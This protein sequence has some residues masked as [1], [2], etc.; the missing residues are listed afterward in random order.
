MKVSVQT[1]AFVGLLAVTICFGWLYLN[2]HYLRGNNWTCVFYTGVRVPM[3]AELAHENI[4]LF[5]GVVGYDAQFYHLIAHDPLFQKGFGHFIDDPRF[6]YR[7]ILIPGL[8]ALLSFGDDSR[9]DSAYIAVVLALV[10]LGAFWLTSWSMSHG[11]SPAWGLLFLVIPATLVTMLLMVVDGALAALTIGAIWY[12]ERQNQKRLFLV[13]ACAALVREIGIF[14]LAGYCLWLLVQRKPRRA[15][16]FGTAALP[17]FLWLWFVQL[18]TAAGSKQMLSAIPFRG[19]Y[20]AV[21]SHWVYRQPVLVALDFVAMGGMLLAFTFAI[22]YFARRETR[23]PAA[24]MVAGFIFLG[25]FVGNSAGIWPEVNSFGRV[26]TPVLLF[27]AMTGL[28]RRNWW[29]LAPIG[30]I[31]LRIGAVFAYHS[32]AVAHAILARRL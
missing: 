9:V 1:P 6:R 4:Y 24:F 15:A 2:T 18:H 14:L 22:Y 19:L 25:V 27:V 29:T 7:R 30:L 26:F 12:A 8:A 17:L 10:Y 5:P 20:G 23:S 32:E 16:I 31:D 11:L 3:P 28:V 21:A 13:F